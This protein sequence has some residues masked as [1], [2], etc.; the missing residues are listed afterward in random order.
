MANGQQ[1]RE[2]L[3]EPSVIISWSISICGKL[4]AMPRL[5]WGLSNLLVPT[6]SLPVPGKVTI[7]SGGQDE[8]ACSPEEEQIDYSHHQRPTGSIR[9]AW[10]RTFPDDPLAGPPGFERECC[11]ARLTA[12]DKQQRCYCHSLL[13]TQPIYFKNVYCLLCVKCGLFFPSKIFIIIY[14]IIYILYLLLPAYHLFPMI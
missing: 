11:S 2:P 12:G 4:A 8:A 13:A 14:I 9:G 1:S 5:R 7:L 6:W 3:K 10:W